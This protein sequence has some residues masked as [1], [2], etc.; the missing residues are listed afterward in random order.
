M[1]KFV[2]LLA[3]ICMGCL[4]ASAQPLYRDYV[5]STSFEL[6]V[7]GG[8]ALPQA[9]GT[10]A[11]QDTWN[12]YLLNNV[13]EKTTIEAKAKKG[14]FLGGFFSLFLN[15]HFGVQL[16]V[17]YLRADV[18]NTAEFNFAWTLYDG[19]K[20]QRNVEW[21]GSGRLVSIPVSLNLLG[22]FG[23]GSFE[24]VFSGGATL[25]NNGFRSDSYFGYGITKLTDLYQ[26][27]DAL[28]VGLKIP[29][30][31]WTAFGGNIGAGL[32]FK[33][34][35][36]IGLNVEARYLACPKKEIAWDFVT[37]RYDGQFF[38]NL[39]P[40]LKNQSFSEADVEYIQEDK[41]MSKITLNPSSFH[42]VVGLVYSFG[43]TQVRIPFH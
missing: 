33:L 19:S 13:V 21:E 8:L 30:T 36:R 6:G 12:Y 15:H 26:Y 29:Q 40:E 23:V 34:S 24:V 39:Y 28:K 18:P 20:Y 3:L 2:V 35:D 32:N 43:N 4:I 37:G 9:K 5:K 31:S 38:S 16:N 17:G 7:F 14:F 22:T 25:F 42:V 41:K 10:T 27:V 11:Y 1:K